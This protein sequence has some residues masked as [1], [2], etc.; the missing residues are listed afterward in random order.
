MI[1]IVDYKVGNLGSIQ[2]ML[3]RLGCSS[4]VTSDPEQISSAEKLILPGVGSFDSGV[5]SIKEH[6]LWDVLNQKVTNE[7]TP[8]LGI[9]LGM[10]LL[11]NKSEEGKERSF[12]W[13]DADV[14]KFNP[15]DK[16]FKTPHMGWNYVVAEQP[17]KLFENMYKNP[18]F[19]F[20]HSY[21]VKSY[22]NSCIGKTTHDI[23]FDSVLEKDNILGTQFHPE[24]SHKFGM[25]LLQNFIERY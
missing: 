11:C 8:V 10:Q 9:C 23:T 14:I 17:S 1:T 7:K 16:Q 2:N 21:Y 6:N 3:K 25:K 15:T 19:Y 20:V 24:K 22:D 5:S 4:V 12:G 13:I 18:K